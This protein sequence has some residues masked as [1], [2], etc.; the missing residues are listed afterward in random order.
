VR[1]RIVVI[2]VSPWSE[3]FSRSRQF[4]LLFFF[5]LFL[6]VLGCGC[7]SGVAALLN[8]LDVTHDDRDVTSVV[9]DERLLLG[10]VQ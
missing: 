1:S 6:G 8:C 2:V 9:V 7:D 4:L 5:V 3:A 10:A